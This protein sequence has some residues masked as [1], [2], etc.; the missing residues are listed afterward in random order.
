MPRIGC[1][2]IGAHIDT[3]RGPVGGVV[4]GRRIGNAGLGCGPWVAQRS[5]RCLV[6]VAL[7]LDGQ[8]DIAVGVVLV[9]RLLQDIVTGDS[10]GIGPGSIATAVTGVLLAQAAGSV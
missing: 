6:M 7:P 3:R 1:A 5:G 10:A 9:L 2:T 8:Q 4:V